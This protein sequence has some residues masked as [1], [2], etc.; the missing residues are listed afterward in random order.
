MELITPPPVTEEVVT[1]LSLAFAAGA[2]KDITLHAGDI[3]EDHG[4]YLTIAFMDGEFLTVYKAA[5]AWKSS[6]TRVIKTPVKTMDVIKQLDLP[7]V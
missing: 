6:R 2:F 3:Y 5:L 4:D 7:V 1:D